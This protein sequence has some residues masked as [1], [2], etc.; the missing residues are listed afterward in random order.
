VTQPLTK[1]QTLWKS[2]LEA[3]R[4]S[5]LSLAQYAEQNHLPL[6]QL[7]AWRSRFKHM[8]VPS[9]SPHCAFVRVDHKAAARTLIEVNLSNGIQLR[10][11]ELTTDLLRILQSV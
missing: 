6:K 2:R 8:N 3:A 7:Y 11:N 4:S 5:G 10:L 1:K 9:N